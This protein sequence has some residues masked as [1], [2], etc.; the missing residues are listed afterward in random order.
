MSKEKVLESL[1]KL[2]KA[3]DGA[4]ALKRNNRGE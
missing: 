3:L 1:D 2:M 4:W